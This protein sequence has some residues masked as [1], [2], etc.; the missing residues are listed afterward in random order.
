MSD[1]KYTPEKWIDEKTIKKIAKRELVG[2]S[3]RRN[4]TIENFVHQ[5]SL[6]TP[7]LVERIDKSNSAYYLVPWEIT[8]GIVFLIE[9]DAKEG[10]LLGIVTYPKPIKF[11]FLSR[12]KALEAVSAKFPHY[13]FVKPK[14]V[15]KPCQESTSPIRPFYQIQFQ[16]G[17]IY[18]DMEGLIYGD[19]T[20][21]GKG[22]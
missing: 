12:S 21:L 9:I 20:P 1:E 11:L 13:T 5:G 3:I 2:Y 22:G 6:G 7:L 10:H 17:N 4:H 18:V 16:K 19:L 8:E 14:L 15:W